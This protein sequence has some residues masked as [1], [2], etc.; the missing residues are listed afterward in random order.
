MSIRSHLGESD[1]FPDFRF[2]SSG[3]VRFRLSGYM[4]FSFS[5]NLTRKRRVCQIIHTNTAGE[6]FCHTHE[7]IPMA[8]S[9]NSRMLGKHCSYCFGMDCISASISE[10]FSRLCGPR[11]STV[12]TTSTIPSGNPYSSR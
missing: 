10:I 2:P 7:R 9:D 12:R 8:V 6:A 1:G 3:S 11:V 4:G 5:G